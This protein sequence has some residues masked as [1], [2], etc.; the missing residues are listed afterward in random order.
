MYPKLGSGIAGRRGNGG[1]R[2]R[3]L[4]SV[5]LPLVPQSGDLERAGALKAGAQGYRDVLYRLCGDGGLLPGGWDWETLR[6]EWSSVGLWA[7][8]FLG[9]EKRSE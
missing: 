6:Q 2:G 8:V 4:P 7:G 9:E 3:T 1:R 5:T